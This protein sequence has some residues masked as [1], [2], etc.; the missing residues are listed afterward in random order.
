M[1]RVALTIK[2]RGTTE[3][4]NW[5]LEFGPWLEVLKPA[6]LRKEVSDLLFAASRTYSHRQ[7]FSSRNESR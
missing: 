4:R 3:I 1:D 5:I 2:V 6:E 7:S